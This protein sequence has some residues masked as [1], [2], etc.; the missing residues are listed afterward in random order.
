MMASIHYILVVTSHY[1]F[2][3]C[4]R[5][6]FVPFLYF[7]LDCELFGQ[8]IRIASMCYM[9]VVKSHRLSMVYM[10]D[11]W[12]PFLKPSKKEKIKPQECHQCLLWQQADHKIV[13]ISSIL[14]EG[15]VSPI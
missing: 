5:D 10:G 6:T 8:F 13:H 7:F 11:T 12:C 14:I 2:N 1:L 4:E 9:P 15:Q 3:F